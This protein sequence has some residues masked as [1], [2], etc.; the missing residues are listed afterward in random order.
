MKI[1]PAIRT[2][3]EIDK[4]AAGLQGTWVRRRNAR[5]TMIA[6]SNELVMKEIEKARDEIKKLKL[7]GVRE[8]DLYKK[9]AEITELE[10]MIIK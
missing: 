7:N 6:W 4:I 8:W 2:E 5:N 1:R 9:Y 3:Q 10:L